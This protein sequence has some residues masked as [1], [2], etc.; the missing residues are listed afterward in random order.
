MDGYKVAFRLPNSL[1]LAAVAHHEDSSLAR[2]RILA[3]CVTSVHQGPLKLAVDELPEAVLTAI[4]D[5]MVESDPLA[6]LDLNLLCPG[7][8]HGWSIGMDIESFLWTEI[9]T[10]AKRLTK[11][12]NVLARA[13]GWSEKDILSMSVPRRQRYVEM[14]NS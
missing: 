9:R 3:R 2:W 8:A 10:Q 6:N 12:V 14:V 13:Y 11:E 5:K 1:D 7:C 4:E